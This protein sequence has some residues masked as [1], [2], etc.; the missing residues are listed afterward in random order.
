[1]YFCG[2][3]SQPR[4]QWIAHSGKADFFVGAR[5][6][7]AEADASRTKNRF[8]TRTSNEARELLAKLQVKCRFCELIK[9]NNSRLL[10]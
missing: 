7:P 3:L 2:T 8:P 6:R 4:A 10:L 5:R 1:M 9:E